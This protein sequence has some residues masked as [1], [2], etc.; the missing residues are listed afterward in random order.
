[1]WPFTVLQWMAKWAADTPLLLDERSRLVLNAPVTGFP[2]TGGPDTSLRGFLLTEDP[3]LGVI[4]TVNGSV[5][6]LQLVAVTEDDLAA[7]RA[8]G[9]PAVVDRLHERDPL[10]ISIVGG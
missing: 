3:E 4:A 2:G 5:R 7:S 8:E 10:A 1:M 9:S 6:F